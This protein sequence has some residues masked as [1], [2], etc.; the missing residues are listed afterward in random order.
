[1]RTWRRAEAAKAAASLINNADSAHPV[2]SRSSLHTRAAPHP[3]YPAFQELRRGAYEPEENAAR[4]W[5]DS[6]RRA[7]KDP[8]THERGRRELRDLEETGGLAIAESPGRRPGS[9]GSSHSA[10]LRCRLSFC[11][12]Q[13]LGRPR[14][15]SE[16]GVPLY[17]ALV[18]QAQLLCLRQLR[19]PC[20]WKKVALPLEQRAPKRRTKS[21]SQN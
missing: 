20:R 8:S 14:L 4:C 12:P 5:R 16:M 19:Q 21:R 15:V 11:L 17:N 2:L 7:R 1:L 13:A 18:R 6:A 9:P 10:V 3:I